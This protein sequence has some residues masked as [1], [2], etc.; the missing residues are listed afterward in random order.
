[1]VGELCRYFGDR[2]ASPEAYVDKVWM[3]DPWTQGAYFSN[4]PP[5]AL[6]SL[7]S[8]LRRPAGGIHWAGSETATHW[9]GYMEG[10][11]QSA[12]RVQ[13]EIVASL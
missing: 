8:E 3:D 10:A 1:M 2:A 9:Y 7:G 5:G 12:E 11:L 4:F 6:T 13:Q